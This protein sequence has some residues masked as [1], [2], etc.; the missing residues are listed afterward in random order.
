M[1][2]TNLDIFIQP[3]TTNLVGVWEADYKTEL[4]DWFQKLFHHGTAEWTIAQ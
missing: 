4:T 3:T 2:C 1:L